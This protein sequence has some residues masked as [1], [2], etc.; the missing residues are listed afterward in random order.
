MEESS[1]C[2]AC[3]ERA[4]SNYHRLDDTVS[5]PLRIALAVALALGAGA[6]VM[7]GMFWLFAGL[8][9]VSLVVMFLPRLLGVRW[10]GGTRCAACGHVVMFR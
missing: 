5:A 9:L 10:W 1:C 8:V 2:H 4:V 7:L 3:G 6:A